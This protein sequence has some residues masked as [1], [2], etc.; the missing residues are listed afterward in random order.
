M[1][2]G[3]I[4]LP[5]Y[6]T[7]TFESSC[8]IV[9]RALTSHQWDKGLI[10]RLCIICGLSLLVLFL[11]LRCF[12]PGTPVFPSSQNLHLICVNFNLQCPQEV[13][14]NFKIKFISF[15][16]LLLHLLFKCYKLAPVKSFLLIFDVFCSEVR[17]QLASFARF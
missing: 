16:W 12:H 5:H 7:I 17:S 4:T 8:G 3:I 11:S 1:H 14:L 9:T 2:D 15:D 10:P 13:C 6:H